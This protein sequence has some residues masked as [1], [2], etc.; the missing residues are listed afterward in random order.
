MN[1]TFFNLQ[2]LFKAV[3]N[4]DQSNATLAD[5]KACTGQKA[6]QPSTFVLTTHK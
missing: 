5:I 3:I 2:K 1:A 6:M 4:N